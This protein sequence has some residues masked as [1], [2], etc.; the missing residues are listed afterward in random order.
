MSIELSW[1]PRAAIAVWLSVIFTLYLAPSP[2]KY[3]AADMLAAGLLVL[4]MMVHRARPSKLA[5]GIKPLTPLLL[6]TAYVLLQGLTPGYAGGMGMQYALQL[7]YGLVPYLLFY[8]IFR[9]Q[10]GTPSDTLLIAALLIPGLVHISYMYLDVLLSIQGGEIAFMTSSKHGFMEYV[11]N[12][13]RVGRRY[14]SMALLHLLCGG[15]LGA[16]Y[17]KDWPLRYGAWILS[18]LSVLSLALLDARAAYASVLIGSLLLTW[19]IGPRKAW[20]SVKNVFHWHSILK[21]VLAAFLVG[22][23]AL[24]YSAGKSRWIAM[25]YSIQVAVQDV[26]YTETPLGARPYVDMTFW[27]NPIP[28][29]DECYLTGQFRCKV[30]QSA[31]LRVAWLLEGAQSLGNHPL[32]IG[33]SENFMGRLWGVEKSNSSYQRVDSFLVEHIVC[34]GWPAVI[35]YGWLFWGIISATRH[36]ALTGQLTLSSI[37]V[38]ALLLACVGRTLVDVFSEGLWKYLMALLGI[39]YGQLHANGL[40]T[41]KD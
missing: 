9:H 19:A 40:K 24:G 37:M 29:V 33:Y 13:P 11:K 34:F 21:L 41:Q 28:D 15:L 25:T 6:M 22:V 26:L 17:A 20:Q 4:T 3:H 1:M 16:A 38:G 31:Y 7:F 10:T 8:L 35:L 2:E 27:S 39:Y 32:G 12:A 23:V 5:A 36:A 30:D 18:G 14:V